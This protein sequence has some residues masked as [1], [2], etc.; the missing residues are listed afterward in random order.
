MSD[1]L[2][3]LIEEMNDRIGKHTAEFEAALPK[4]VT[5]A[6][7]KQDA[8]NS[9][10]ATPA[11]ATC[12]A[13][14]VLGGLMTCAQLGLRPGV[15]GLG[16]AWLLPMKNWREKRTDATLIIGY[17][18]YADLA[19]RHPRV[20]A[21]VSNIV[22]QGDVFEMDLG[23]D[24]L[25][26]KMP[27]LGTPRGSA[28]GFYAMANI[29]GPHGTQRIL[30][31]PMSLADMQAHRDKF[32]M[33]KNKDGIVGPWRDHFDEMG[34]KGLALDTP[35]PTVDGWSTM[36][37]L[38]VGDQV[39]DMY[40]QAT[41]VRAVSEVKHIDCY[42][43]TFANGASIVCDAEHY[44]LANLGTNASRTTASK[45]W[46]VYQIADLYEAKQAG[47][48]VVMPVV[49]PLDTKPAG[50][51]IDP[52]MLG[53]W[54][55][56]GA[57]DNAHVTC[58]ADDLE[59]IKA[60]ITRS[61]YTVGAVRT[62]PRSK[63]VGIGV[64]GLLAD[65][66]AASVLGRKHVPA[67]Y[68]RA[69]AEQRLALLQ[70]LIDSDGTIDTERGRVYFSSVDKGLADAV[71]E[72]ARSLGEVVNQSERDTTGYGKTV[73]AYEVKWKPGV[74]PASLARKAGR[75]RTRMLRLYR[76]VKS[77]ELIPSVPTR[78]IEVDSATR[79]YAAGV[80]MVPTHNTMVRARLVK[81]IPTALDM[82]VALSVD[83]GIRTDFDPTANPVEVTTHPNQPDEDEAA[84]D[85]GQ[86]V[87][88]SVTIRAAF[89]TGGLTGTQDRE[90]AGLM[91]DRK[92]S[93]DAALDMVERKFGERKSARQLTEEQA[94]E[95]IE[96]LKKIPLPTMEGEVL[97]PGRP[98]AEP[99]R[100]TTAVRMATR[101]Q[102]NMIHAALA[103]RNITDD[104]A[105]RAEISRILG[106]KI[107]SRKDVTF[108][109]A[110]RVLDHLDAP[111]ATPAEPPANP[112]MP[113]KDELVREHI[114]EMIRAE[115]ARAGGT[116]QALAGAFRKAMNVGHREATNNELN[117]FLTRFRAGKH[118]PTSA[119]AR[120]RTKLLG[121]VTARFDG[122]DEQLSSEERL[123]DM[124]RLLNRPVHRLQDLTAEEVDTVHEVLGD[125]AGLAK[126]WDDAI[127]AA[128]AAWTAQQ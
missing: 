54:L 75:F 20:V 92:M 96:E 33:A 86:T 40:G 100:P 83:E 84:A 78:C 72:L 120:Q 44:W 23:A 94:A 4:G 91:R 10:R 2:P 51:P 22:R 14:S 45:G 118:Q 21:V 36:G 30:T 103:D 9:L 1:N 71:A 29:Q 101:P 107:E 113:D 55:G 13:P 108:D 82:A 74:C 87:R 37:E 24:L 117:A 112:S 99:E 53:Y 119:A 28:I 106:E 110:A 68:L 17:R 102:M 97:T 85:P 79:T 124:S 81:A 27:P 61:G 56:N 48:A 111:D 15:A 80:E 95:L 38:K 50:L 66:R 89:P 3:A 26:H 128:E 104:D 69:S 25:T 32:A 31:E 126:K 6:Q 88:E 39:F 12:H 62:D 65:L 63:G 8:L 41:A 35:I 16:H 122:L 52:W 34:R 93:K 115:W 58:H 60:A 125:C 7:L 67:S 57:K 46:T 59:E 76:G 5:V 47:Q 70:G 64:R 123:R 49:G 114:V 11:L 18:G 105:V 116:P 127:R 19:Y 73:H 98:P 77:I 121:E 109:Q 42:R 43:V 90:I